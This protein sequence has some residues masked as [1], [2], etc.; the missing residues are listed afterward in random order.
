MPFTDF[1][2]TAF[3]DCVPKSTPR[4]YPE[5]EEKNEKDIVEKPTLTTKSEM[6]EVLPTTPGNLPVV[7]VSDF[8]LDDTENSEEMNTQEEELAEPTEEELKARLNELLG[9]KL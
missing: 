4:L 5:F 8:G 6:P 1:N 2:S 7:D 9:G 3:I